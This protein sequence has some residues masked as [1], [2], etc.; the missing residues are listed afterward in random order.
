MSKTMLP[1]MGLLRLMS[2]EAESDSMITYTRT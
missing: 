1:D 2:D